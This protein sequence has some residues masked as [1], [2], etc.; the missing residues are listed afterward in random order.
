MKYKLRYEIC[1][2]DSEGRE[3]QPPMMFEEGTPDKMAKL[4]LDDFWNCI[5][6]LNDPKWIKEYD[7]FE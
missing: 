3:A 1:V 4:M 6:D 5:R 2:T 7:E